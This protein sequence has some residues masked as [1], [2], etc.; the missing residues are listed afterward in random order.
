DLQYGQVHVTV[1]VGDNPIALSRN[2]TQGLVSVC[3]NDASRIPQNATELRTLQHARVPADQQL[4][5][6]EAST[7]VIDNLFQLG[8]RNHLRCKDADHWVQ[9]FEPC[10]IKRSRLSLNACEKNLSFDWTFSSPRLDSCF[11]FED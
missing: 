7:A 10:R 9:P 8:P 11:A 4:L 5:H 1:L 2:V 6:C 3:L